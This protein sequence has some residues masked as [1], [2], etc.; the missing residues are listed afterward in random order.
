MSSNG[1]FCELHQICGSTVNVGDLLGF[2]RTV[3]SIDGEEEKAIAVVKIN[4]GQKGCRVDFLARYLYG[5]VD[6]SIVIQVVQLYEHS[7]STQDRMRSY[8]QGGMALCKILDDFS[9]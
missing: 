3:V 6:E 1:R 2:Q 4:S 5:R 7:E 8:R 9:Y